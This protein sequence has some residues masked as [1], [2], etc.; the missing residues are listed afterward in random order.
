MVWFYKRTNER[1][2]GLLGYVDSDYVEDLDKRMF[3]T[4]YMFIFYGCLINW[5]ATLQHVVAL[6]TSEAKYT[7]TTEAIKVSL[8]LQGYMGELYMK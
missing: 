8:W 6:L 4:G 3:L 2:E 5:K 7:T 1:C